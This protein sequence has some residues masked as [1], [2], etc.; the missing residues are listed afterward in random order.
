MLPVEAPITKV[1]VET[2][3]KSMVEAKDT[4]VQESKSKAKVKTKTKKIAAKKKS[5]KKAKNQDDMAT[6]SF[7][8][9]DKIRLSGDNGTFS[10]GKVPAGTYKLLAT[11]NG[12]EM[13]VKELTL[14]AGQVKKIR[15]NSVFKRCR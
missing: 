9:A 15:C 11:F 8:G 3:S 13:K 14:K 5:K 12:K 4:V 2:E 10:S 1:E 7:S 6:V